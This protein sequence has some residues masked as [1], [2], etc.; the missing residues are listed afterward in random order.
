MTPDVCPLCDCAVAP[1]PARTVPQSVAAG[2]AVDTFGSS[3]KRAGV[4]HVARCA[5]CGLGWQ[6]PMPTAEALNEIY[7][8]ME[9]KHRLLEVSRWERPARRYLRLL[10]RHAGGVRGRL[11][12]VGCSTGVFLAESL[13]H[14]WDAT[15]I[16][17]SAWLASHAQARL[18]ARVLQTTLEAAVFDDQSFTAVTLWD[19]LEHMTDPVGALRKVI[20]LL[21]PGG[22]VGV[23]VPNIDSLPSRF[24]GTHWP[25]V[26]PEHTFYF[27]PRSLRRLFERSGLSWLG[28]HD[29]PVFFSAGFV[30]ER[31]K[32]H[33]VPCAGLTARIL[34]ALKL[35]AVSI[36]VLMGDMTVFARRST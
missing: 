32:Q 3:R 25:M 12:D 21:R 14:G 30:V 29:H 7:R 15:G 8:S 22:I 24:L 2:V 17:P 26:L 10:S 5:E 13:R 27:A 35:D 9:D 11:L 20:R 31:L 16:E 36:P 19:V 34:Q 23:N 4:V 33:E 1:R 6:S 28:A 18:G